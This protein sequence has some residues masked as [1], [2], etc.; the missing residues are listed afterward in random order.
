MKV[1]ELHFQRLGVKRG[2]G[3]TAVFALIASILGIF[4]ARPA[5]A[6]DLVNRDHVAREVVVNR[7]N[8]SSETINVKP[9]QKL[10]NICDDCVILAG[11]SSVETRGRTTVK[12][13]GGQVLLDT[14][15]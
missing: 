5:G 7:A 13:E 10:E 12:I 2:F 1:C 14:K 9:G 8:G 4:A 3:K 11:A 6:V 15:R